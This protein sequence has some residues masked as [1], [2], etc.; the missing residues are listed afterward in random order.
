MCQ[1]HIGIL[2]DVHEKWLPGYDH[3]QKIMKD[4]TKKETKTRRETNFRSRQKSKEYSQ[5]VLANR[6]RKI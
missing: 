2:K 5:S 1:L 4:Q 3:D 6:D